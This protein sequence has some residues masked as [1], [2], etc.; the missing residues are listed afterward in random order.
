M[1][2]SYR[3]R[4]YFLETSRV[5]RR[6]WQ[7][8]ILSALLLLPAMPVFAQ[9]QI[10][11]APVLAALAPVHGFE[12]RLVWVHML[13]AVGLLW[14]LI[15]RTAITGGAF[16]A[17]LKSLPTS[18]RRRR[19]I[20]ITLV[21]IAST[22]LL[23]PILAAAI[24]LAALPHKAINYLFV[25]DLTL[26]TLGWQLTALSCNVRN[27]LPLVVAN[28]ILIGGF[29]T[30]YAI[31]LVSLLIPLGLA[32]F[33]IAHMPVVSALRPGR[34]GAL[35][36]RVTGFESANVRLRL[37]P[38]IKLQ[39]CILGGR[40]AGTLSRFLLMGAVT[41]STCFLVGLW[42]FDARVVPL[43][44]IAQAAIALIAATTYRDLHA[45][46]LR[47]AHFMHSLPLARSAQVRTDI[48]TVASLALPFA[49]VAPLLLVA[50]GILSLWAA[51]VILLSG[52]PL[53]ALLRLPQ[54]YAP[55]ESVL[56][57]AMLTAIWLVIAWQCFA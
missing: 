36:R 43:T 23:L 34:S 53:L 16:A 15:Q 54:R 39:V 41:A 5:L 11:G 4:W 17:Y 52:A 18:S 29:Q 56:L 9:A 33:V 22:P 2:L 48:L 20:D 10:L 49:A 28:V 21:L 8:L 38:V 57:S 31:R 47:A 45:A 30:D 19:T 42:N 50:Q 26:I 3:L 46:H 1:M 51:A 32:T 44:L 6:H 40:A 37:P 55:R 7:A 12:W 24:A 13:E 14:V 25:L 27:A 35:L